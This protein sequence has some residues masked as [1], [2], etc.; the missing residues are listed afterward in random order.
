MT[1]IPIA[2]L[3][4]FSGEEDNAQ[5]WIN[6]VVKRDIEAV[7]TY[8]GCFYQNLHQ[9]QAINA[10][11]FITAQILNQFIHELWSS[12][13]QY[14]W[15]LHPVNLQDAVTCARDF[16]S[17]ELEANHVQAINLVMNGSSDLDSKLKQFI[18]SIVII[19]SAVAVRDALCK[20]RSISIHLSVNDV[21]AYLLTICIS[22]SSL[23]IAATSNI[24]TIATSNLSTTAT[25][26]TAP[27]PYPDD[28]KKPQI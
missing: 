18:T 19:Q 28:I 10:D 12:I 15:L 3:E 4:K 16:E 9:I 1:Y 2:K 14:I 20:S 17:A 13:L 24:S 7:T 6:N 11:Y 25:S 5:A 22:T 21:A 27:K 23:L 8:L 26:N